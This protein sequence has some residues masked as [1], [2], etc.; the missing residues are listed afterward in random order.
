M[1]ALCKSTTAADEHR[2]GPL[3]NADENGLTNSFKKIARSFVV[4]GVHLR[5]ESVFICGRF[6]GLLLRPALHNYRVISALIAIRG[7][8]VVLFG[9]TV[10][11]DVG[12]RPQGRRNH[13]GLSVAFE[14]ANT[15]FAR[16]TQGSWIRQRHVLA[17]T[18]P[19]S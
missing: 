9:R 2:F 7:A 18:L 10:R 11:C 6:C 4:I 13:E 12:V 1:H 16:S 15:A 8:K 19:G 17:L 14:D 5:T 3:M